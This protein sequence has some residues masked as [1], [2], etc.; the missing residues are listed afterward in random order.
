MDTIKRLCGYGEGPITCIDMHTT[1]E[2]T[3][4]IIS[5]YPHLSGTLLQQR[6]Q[7]KSQHDHIRKRL[8]LEPAGHVDMYGA[9]LRP[10]T[11]LTGSGEAHIGVLFL[12]NEGYSTM[13]GHATIALGRFLIDTHDL[14]VFPRRNDVRINE[15]SKTA[16][17]H[18]HAPC[19]LV[20]V[21]VPMTADLARSDPSRPV[22]FICVPSFATGA[23]IRVPI[24]PQNR[25][26]EMEKRDS[27]IVSF[28]Y[29]GAFTCL[30][31][32]QELGFGEK[33]LH[34]PVDQDAM[35]RATRSLKSVINQ[36]PRYRKY[37][38]HPEHEELS[39]LYTIMVVDKDI[40][41]PLGTSLG[42][43]TGL[44]YFAD[45]QVDRSPTGSAVAARVAYAYATGALGMGQSWT[46]HSLVSN[47]AQGKGG[48][49]GT[50]VEEVLDLY[51][52]DA[53]LAPPIRVKVEGY[54]YYVGSHVFVAEKD[55][56]YQ[57][58]GFMFNRL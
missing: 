17:L 3:R 54:A 57:G 35:S 38:R 24:P 12:H 15:E 43:E 52:M 48:F 50:A 26:P 47:A 21:T 46:Y 53:M 39:S 49:V 29:G 13:C 27:I 4:I 28:C 9:V 1:G 33:G 34:P 20:V 25:W 42:A 31:T 30:I 40:G 10:D 44:C 23:N 41:K 51:D 2:P 16:A 14:S 32:T 11:E 37:M 6:A 45:Q 18:L 22:S 58:G 5:G 56:P 36:D 7:A 19:G 55:D 8:M